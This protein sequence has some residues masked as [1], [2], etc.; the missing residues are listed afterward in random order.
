MKI[1]S[2]LAFGVL[3]CSV[4][5]S[6]RAEEVINDDFQG[7]AGNK[8]P[9]N[10]ESQN[11]PDEP[12]NGT[13]G[14]EYGSKDNKVLRFVTTGD[15]GFPVI[16]NPRLVRAFEPVKFNSKGILSLEFDYRNHGTATCWVQIGLGSESRGPSDVE[17]VAFNGTPLDK[18]GGFYMRQQVL[19]AFPN[20]IGGKLRNIEK[21]VWYR[22]KLEVNLEEKICRLVVRNLASQAEWETEWLPCLVGWTDDD[23][24]DQVV[25]GSQ[26]RPALAPLWTIRRRLQSRSAGAGEISLYRRSLRRPEIRGGILR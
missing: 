22:I 24:L 7:Y 9:K 8:R 19:K 16:D 4:V 23:V 14:I 13:I 1:P 11:F 20:G 5:L 18:G 6:A 21:G 15:E 26:D 25:L 3:L 10:L 17:A 2:A 12:N